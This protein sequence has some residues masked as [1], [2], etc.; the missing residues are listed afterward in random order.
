MKLNK[1]VFLIL[2]PLVFLILQN[3]QSPEGMPEPAWDILS[4]TFWIALWWVTEAVPIAVTALLP[5]VLFP[6]TGAL[7]L[8]TTTASYGHKYIFLYMGGFILAI[9]IEKWNLHKRIALHIIK[10]IGTN[11]RKIILGFMVATAFLSMWISNTATSVMMLPIGMS[12]VS[13]LKDDKRTSQDENDVFGKALMLSIAYSA[14]IGGIATLIGTPPNLVFA[15]YIQEVYAIDI[16]FFQWL[17]FGLPISIILLIGSW[18]YITHVAFKFQE[19]KFSRGKEEIQRLITELGPMKREE[20]VVLLVFLITAIAWIS[21]SFILEKFF[22]GIDDTIIA[23]IAAICLFTIGTSQK[24]NR[25]I[26]WKDALNIPW[27]IILLFGGGMALA[28]GFEV[29]GLAKWIG[30]QMTLLQAFPLLLLVLVVI[31]SVNFITE[32]TSNLATTAMLL[33]ILAPIAL[34]LDLNPYML[35]VATTVAASCAF[36]LP[37]ATPPNAVV[38]GSGYLR[39]PDMVRTGIWMNLISILFLTLMVYF[40]LPLIWE[41]EPFGFSDQFKIEKP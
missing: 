15:G 6:L 30:M 11:I 3:I 19:K 12:I 41:F 33:P 32:L 38:F 23:M 7:D 37:V 9:A 28:S 16:S 21:R 20:K 5:I 14:S 25:I 26:Q 40:M 1:N 31:F 36:M 22:P 27:G 10:L 4:A 18:F 2:G 34:K 13:Q 24:G 35:L 29:T 8:S 39:I 17:K